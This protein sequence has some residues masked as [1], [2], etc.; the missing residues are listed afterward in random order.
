MLHIASFTFVMRNGRGEGDLVLVARAIC[1]Y[2]NMEMAKGQTL[3]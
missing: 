3:R 2:V 1:V